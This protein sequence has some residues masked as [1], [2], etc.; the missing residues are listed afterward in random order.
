MKK[1]I[2]FFVAVLCT[3]L[4]GCGN[5]TAAPAAQSA[6]QQPAEQETLD[7]ANPEP[8]QIIAFSQESLD[9]LKA[10]HVNN[11]DD[12]AKLEAKFDEFQKKTAD[13]SQ[14]LNDLLPNMSDEEKAAFVERVKAVEQKIDENN[15]LFEKEINRLEEEAKAAGVALDLDGNNSEEPASKE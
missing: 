8:E 2:R 4:V 15:V 1:M 14:A 6:E 9:F 12:A 5:K 7:L 10:A 3:V 11:A 13:F